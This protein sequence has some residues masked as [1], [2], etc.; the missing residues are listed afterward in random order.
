[1]GGAA[2]QDKEDTSQSPKRR[3][4]TTQCCNRPASRGAYSARNASGPASTERA[5]AS[6]A[7]LI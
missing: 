6:G 1:M 7:D 2:G 4:G 3:W 5:G